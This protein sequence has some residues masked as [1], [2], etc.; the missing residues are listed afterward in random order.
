MRVSTS[1]IFDSS[2]QSMNS[3]LTEALKSQ[4]QI[5]TGQKF[6]KASDDPYAVSWGVRLSF[7]KSRLGMY[8]NNQKFVT[9]SMDNAATQLGSI[10]DQMNQLNSILVQAQN[11]SLNSTALK[12]L[13]LEADQIKQTITSQ[14][15]TK[16]ASGNAIFPSA[17]NQ[18]QIEPNVNVDS[19]IKFSDSFGGVGDGTKVD[20]LTKINEFVAFLG[21]KAG[22][23]G[24]NSTGTASS[25]STG[26]T[27]AYN[28]LQDSQ[29]RS[30]LVGSLVS[31]SASAVNSLGTQLAATTSTLLDTDM[32]AAT[33]SFMKSQAILNA[34][35]SLFSRLQSSNLFSKM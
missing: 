22:V 32:A 24:I 4:N 23:G 2:T 21:Q 25:V 12:A 1:Q 9:A 18:V 11:G 6:T 33:A 35:Q 5:S 14:S 19:G 27:S 10:I 7:D 3:S 16:D 28:Q 31:Q 29:T 8:E 34:A 26:L 15:A 20:V 30:G 17:I 13:Y